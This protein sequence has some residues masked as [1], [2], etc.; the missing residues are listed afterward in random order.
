ML[1]A[2]VVFFGANAMAA[3]VWRMATKQPID[4]PEGKVFQ[5]F[6]ELT[7]KYTNGE[8]KI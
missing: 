8:L 4:S 3:D 5:R 7:D 1:F 2:A 6:A